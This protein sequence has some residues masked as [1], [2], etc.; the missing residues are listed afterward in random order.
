[1]CPSRTS[2]SVTSQQTKRATLV[3]RQPPD[4]GNLP[5][6]SAKW[7]TSVKEH[8][9]RRHNILQKLWQWS[10]CGLGLLCVSGCVCTLQV[11]FRPSHYTWLPV[12]PV[13][14]TGLKSPTVTRLPYCLFCLWLNNELDPPSNAV[15]TL[16]VASH[17]KM[18]HDDT[19][20]HARSHTHTHTHTHRQLE[21]KRKYLNT[22]ACLWTYKISLS[23]DRP[24]TYTHKLRHRPLSEPL[25][26]NA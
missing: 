26:L 16:F 18:T 9:N 2:L 17:D 22:C 20:T 5:P 12:L 3:S 23:Q 14:N 4:W 1:M 24:H 13:I 21:R 7:V 15:V 25:Q 6:S 8:H 19:H 11:L 10:L